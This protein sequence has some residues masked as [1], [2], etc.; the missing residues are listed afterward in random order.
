MADLRRTVEELGHSDVETYL[1]SGNVVFR[2]R[3]RSPRD[4]AGSLATAISREAGFDV[5]VVVRTGAELRKVV[6]GS[7]YPL[8]DP[9]RQLVG[10]LA[11]PLKLEE[12]GLGD[13]EAY[14]PDELTLAGP[15]VYVSVPT[16]QA[17]SKL[18]QALTAP[19]LGT[20]L[21][22]RNW[23]TVAALAELTAT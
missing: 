4:L 1:Q 5:E 7:P 9:T 16:G 14:L 12:L 3:A 2:P 13:L 8:A 22:L 17:R 6:A 11:R 15:D 20:T 19:R 10:F 23:R 21:T 18:V